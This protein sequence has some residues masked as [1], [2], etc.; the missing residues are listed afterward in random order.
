M[1][2]APE[3]RD[4]FGDKREAEVFQEM[5]AEHP[6]KADGHVGIAGKI[7]IDLHQIRRRRNPRAAHGQVRPIQSE[8]RI[9]QQTQVVCQYRL[10]AEAHQEAVHARHE[11]RP[12]F[13]APFNFVRYCLIAHDRA[14]DQLRE[15]R[16][17][18]AN[19][20]EALL[21]L[22]VAAIDVDD[23]AHRLEGKE[24]YADGQR[25]FRHGER[26]IEPRPNVAQQPAQVFI[27]AQQPKIQHHRQHQRELGVPAVFPLFLAVNPQRQQPVHC[28]GRHHNRHKLRLSPGIEAQR[29]YGEEHIARLAPFFQNRV[30]RQHKGEKEI[31]EHI[32]GKYH[33]EL[34]LNSSGNTA[35][36]HLCSG[37]WCARPCP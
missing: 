4:R 35:Q 28:N 26:Q 14:G 23:I 21:H 31:Q 16:H 22:A 13:H 5:E 34:L 10:F 33:T 3:A 37:E 15:E 17:I 6:A 11:I 18:Q 12:V 30:A 25:D 29:G 20:E 36:M 24:R 9:H 32:A 19:V 7:V 8:Q 2:P 1:P 27:C